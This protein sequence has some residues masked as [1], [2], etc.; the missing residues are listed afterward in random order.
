MGCLVEFTNNIILKVGEP[1]VVKVHM[2]VFKAHSS[3]QMCFN[4]EREHD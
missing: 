4:Y 1:N 2:L 3:L